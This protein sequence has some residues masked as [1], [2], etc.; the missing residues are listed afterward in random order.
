M[1]TM[2][3]LASDTLLTAIESGMP[4]TEASAI[5][6]DSD[7]NILS[8][9]LACGDD[10]ED[11]TFTVTPADVARA[12]WKILKTEVKYADGLRRAISNDLK[13]GSGMLIDAPAAWGIVEVAMFGE[14]VYC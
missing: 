5:T 7:L 2:N 6:R 12:M 14:V 4:N 9:T 13:N 1:E 8:V 10:G 3:Q 11:G